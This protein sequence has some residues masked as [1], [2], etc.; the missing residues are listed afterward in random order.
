MLELAVRG[1]DQ[2]LDVRNGDDVLDRLSRTVCRRHGAV[3]IPLLLDG[4]DALL[5]STHV[6]YL[7]RLP[8]KLVLVDLAGG[9]GVDVLQIRVDVVANRRRGRPS[10]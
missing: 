9:N 4:G 2:V 7:F 3:L 6:V 10:A 8:E 1:S 5:V